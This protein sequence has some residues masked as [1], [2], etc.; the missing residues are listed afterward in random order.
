MIGG[1]ARRRTESARSLRPGSRAA[2]SISLKAE[3]RLVQK[4]EAAIDRTRGPRIPRT[5]DPKIALLPDC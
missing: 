2:F 4:A 3:R 5:P 1:E